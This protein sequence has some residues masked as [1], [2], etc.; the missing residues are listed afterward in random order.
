MENVSY[1]SESK[2]AAWNPGI[3]PLEAE[4]LLPVQYNDLIRKRHTPDGETK[5]MLAVLKDAIRA[6]IRNIDGRNAQ[7]RREFLETYQWFHSQH[8]DGVFAY[9]SV[10]WALGLE[11]SVLRRW[12]KSLHKTEFASRDCPAR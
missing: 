7:A 12:L 1:L 4:C 9:E 8:Q 11:P 2:R 3:S 6:Y 10:C 5:L